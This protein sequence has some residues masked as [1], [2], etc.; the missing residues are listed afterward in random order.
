MEDS[1]QAGRPVPEP[2]RR[3]FVKSSQ[4]PDCQN[5]RLII[6]SSGEFQSTKSLQVDPNFFML[7]AGEGVEWGIKY[8]K[9][10]GIRQGVSSL[11]RGLNPNQK[12]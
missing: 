5:P 9:K 1:S 6:F 8:G 11:K 3:C 2:V 7:Q 12:K 4:S 10:S